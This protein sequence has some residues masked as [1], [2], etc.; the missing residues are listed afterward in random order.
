VSVS[1]PNDPTVLRGVVKPGYQYGQGGV[2][3]PVLLNETRESVRRQQWCVSIHD[4]NIPAETRKLGLSH[5]HGIARPTLLTLQGK[6]DPV[7]TADTL[8]LLVLIAD[9]NNEAIWV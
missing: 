7:S 2:L 3:S 1:R 5:S 9:H 6:Y 4:Q 8:Y